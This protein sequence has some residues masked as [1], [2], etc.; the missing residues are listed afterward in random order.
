MCSC[1]NDSSAPFTKTANRRKSRYFSP[2][3]G[4]Q[5]ISGYPFERSIGQLCRPQPARY[6]TTW[7]TTTPTTHSHQRGK[8]PAEGSETPTSLLLFRSEHL[9]DVLLEMSHKFL[10]NLLLLN[11]SKKAHFSTVFSGSVMRSQPCSIFSQNPYICC[12]TTKTKHKL[13]V[14]EL[15]QIFTLWSFLKTLITCV[16]QTNSDVTFSTLLFIRLFYCSF[17]FTSVI[18]P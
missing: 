8:P 7:N 13:K 6:F 4:F 17:F 1:E 3:Q 11:S 14:P 10:L 16:Y 9:L 15:Y 12:S 18:F 5:P 2:P